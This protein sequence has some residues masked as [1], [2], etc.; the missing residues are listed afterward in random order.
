M[1]LKTFRRFGGEIIPFCAVSGA[2]LLS[3]ALVRYAVAPQWQRY[4]ALTAE[5]SHMKSL[6]SDKNR[7]QAIKT[8]LLDKQ[9]L[10]ART[11]A[12]IAPGAS[13]LAAA[14]LSGL[15][16][17]LISRAREADIRFVKMLPQPESQRQGMVD[18]P[19]ILEMTTSYQSLGRFV[20][21]LEELPQTI[22]VERLALTA[23]KNALDVRILVTC[24][25]NKAE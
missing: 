17:L 3:L 6:V 5:V 21:S 10:L 19:V 8:R 16:Q 22:R 9:Q 12:R 1:Y 23:R 2:V 20:S 13:G 11:C 14:D 24:F 25:L 18:F 7:Y 15:M 4:G